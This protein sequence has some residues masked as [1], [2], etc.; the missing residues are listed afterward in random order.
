M[1]AGGESRRLGQDKALVAIGGVPLLH[2]V[3]EALA[4]AVQ[5]C[6]VVVRRGRSYPLPPGVRLVEDSPPYVGPLA[7]LVSGLAASSFPYAFCASCDLPFLD[8]ALVHHL[9]AL[10]H[11]GGWDAV[12]PRVEGHLQPAHAAYRRQCVTVGMRLLGAGRT[13][14]YALVGAV[15]AHIVEGE[16]LVAQGYSLRSFT[17][18]NTPE[19]LGAAQC[20]PG[21]HAP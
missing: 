12:V 13:S 4:P 7:G 16:A 19:D 11:K 21:E 8:T 5:E 20:L 10:A 18:V 1:L 9:L 14:L 15:R 2:R 17:N 3:L 6:L